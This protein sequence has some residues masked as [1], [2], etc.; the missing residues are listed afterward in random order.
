GWVRAAKSRANRALEAEVDWE[1]AVLAAVAA[2]FEE[3]G[4]DAAAGAL[5]GAALEAEAAGGAQEWVRIQ[6]SETGGGRPK[7]RFEGRSSF[8][9]ETRR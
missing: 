6:I 7:T 5:A 8:Q 2:D 4:E 9:W 3:A 1:A